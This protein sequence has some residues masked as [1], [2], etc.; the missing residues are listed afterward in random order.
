MP[1]ARQLSKGNFNSAS[2][3]SHTIDALSSG[4]CEEALNYTADSLERNLEY[5]SRRL[6]PI[7]FDHASRIYSHLM[8]ETDGGF[9]GKFLVHTYELYDNAFAFGRV[10]RYESV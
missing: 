1:A 10:R 3:Q 2:G 7:Y 8:N 6:D 5:F 4:P 9:K